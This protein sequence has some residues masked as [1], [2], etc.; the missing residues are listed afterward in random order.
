MTAAT[1]RS[2]TVPTGSD[3]FLD[4]GDD[5]L[6]EKCGV[7]GISG[8]ADAA[9]LTAL[10]LH[11][12]QHRGQ[13]AAGIVSFDGKRFHSERRLGLVGDNFSDGKT[14]ERLSGDN[15][16]GHTRYSTTGETILRNVQPVF[17]ELDGGGFALAHNGNLT[18]GLSL[19]RQLIREGAIYQST[20]D[21]E[22]ILHLVARS[23]RNRFI[24]RLIDALAPGGRGLCACGADK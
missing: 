20:S 7:F 17:A 18:N 21:T 6:R 14:I 23:R 2:E 15:A 16:I 8:H 13:E 12:L 1:M 24:D 9:A 10:G 22:V 4:D 11:A 3:V 5:G 19:R